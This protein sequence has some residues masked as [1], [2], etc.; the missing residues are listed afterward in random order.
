M[1][2]MPILRAFALF[3]LAA[4]LCPIVAQERTPD[5]HYAPTPNR[6]V[7]KMLE[8]ANVTSRDVVYDLGS[9]DGRIV[10]MAAKEFG[11]RGV[12]IEIDRRLI[13]K[14]RENARKEGVEDRVEFRQQDLFKT[15]LADA[16]VVAT[17][18]FTHLNA[19]LAP[20]L[21][22]LRRGTRIVAHSFDMGDDWPPDKEVGMVG[23][24]VSLWTVK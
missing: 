24:T 23:S 10:I 15:D 19:R 7:R 12:G 9:G 16:T 17:Y 22:R 2:L 14:S 4:A 18:L 21:K 8:L 11:A 3:P 6:V 13:A 20:K 1:E 5:V